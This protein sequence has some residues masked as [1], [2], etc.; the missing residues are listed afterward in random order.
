MQV[1]K[2]CLQEDGDTKKFFEAGDACKK[3]VCLKIFSKPGHSSNGRTCS[4]KQ[5]ICI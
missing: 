4:G 1:K 3:S 5:Y 2:K